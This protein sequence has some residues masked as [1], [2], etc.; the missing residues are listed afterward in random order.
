MDIK[1]QKFFQELTQFSFIDS[2]WLYGSRARGDFTERS[3]I[4]IAIICPSASQG[5]WRKILEIIENADTL[6]KIDCIRFD[7]LKDQSV[8]KRNIEKDRKLLFQKRGSMQ[9]KVNQKI[10]FLEKALIKLDE[11]VNQPVSK[12][13]SEIDSSIQRFEFCFELSWK[14][15]KIILES[16]GQNE[17]FPKEVLKAAYQGHLIDNQ[18]IWLEMLSDRNNISHVYDE[19]VADQVYLNIKSTYLN[20]LKTTF[21]LIKT[22]FY[23]K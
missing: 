18:D 12:N 6:L 10:M 16:L 20:T 3:D 8:L 4:D 14:T 5:D 22:R 21:A 11:M 17:F 13:R 2:I 23:I 1:A 9:D 19:V 15:L 7:L